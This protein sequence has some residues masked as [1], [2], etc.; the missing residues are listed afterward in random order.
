[1][2]E[3]TIKGN[4]IVKESPSSYPKIPSSHSNKMR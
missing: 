4:Y 2:R 3:L 1:M